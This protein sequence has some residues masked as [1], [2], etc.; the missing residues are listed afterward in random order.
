MLGLDESQAQGDLPPT[1]ILEKGTGATVTQ[2]IY[3]QKGT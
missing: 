1:S 3:I 2:H